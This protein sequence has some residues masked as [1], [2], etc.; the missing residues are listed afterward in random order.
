MVQNI[1]SIAKIEYAF[2][3]HI[4]AIRINHATSIIEEIIPSPC[5]GSPEGDGGCGVGPGVGFLFL[6]FYFTPL[7]ADI[8]IVQKQSDAGTLYV[9][10][11]KA[12]V[13]KDRPDAT[14]FIRSSQDCWF[15]LKVTDANGTARLIG[16]PDFPA[17]FTARISVPASPSRYNGYDVAFASNQLTPP[18]YF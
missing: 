17:Q 16:T 5:G 6:P 4:A 14:A 12:R 2:R 3:E 9:C 18:V 7:S 10:T 1:A 15:L 11:V 8:T 13:P